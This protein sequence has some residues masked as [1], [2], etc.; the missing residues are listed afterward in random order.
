[1]DML[2]ELH[3]MGTVKNAAQAKKPAVVVPARPAETTEDAI[4]KALATNGSKKTV[5]NVQNP[6][7]TMGSFKVFQMRSKVPTNAAPPAVRPQQLNCDV[8]PVGL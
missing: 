7:T 4:S 2:K 1:M 3:K 5:E 6:D 8:V